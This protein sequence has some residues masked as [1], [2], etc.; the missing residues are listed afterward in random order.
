M[1]A[2]KDIS[3]GRAYVELLIKNSQFYKQLKASQKQLEAWGKSIA[4]IGA[5][6]AAAGAAI[7]APLTAAAH[8]FAESGKELFN[9]SARTGVSAQALSEL[10]FAARRTG[11]DAEGLEHS[12]KHMTKHVGEATLGNQ[13]AAASL[14]TIGLN[15][16]MLR[17]LSIDKQ[18]E[19]IAD[20]IA[21]V[22]DPSVKAAAA[23]HI[24]G[25]NGLALMPL[26]IQGSRGIQALRSEAQKLGVSRSDTSVA[27]A[28]QLAGL[29]GRMKE[30][31]NGTV[32]AI[33]QALAPTMIRI[34]QI[35]NSAL[36]LVQ[37]FVKQYGSLVPVIFT[38][39]SGLVI[40]G[41]AIAAFGGSVFA[42]GAAFG[43]I[44][45]TVVA[46]GGFLATPLGI[47]LAIGAAVL[48]AAVQ[49]MRL[50]EI[51]KQ[52]AGV[53]WQMI[54]PAVE[55]I[56]A[57]F[58]GIG[59]AIAGGDLVLAGKIAV[60]GLR[61]V[62]MQGI[63]LLVQSIHATL[64]ETF[65]AIAEDIIQGDLAGAWRIVVSGMAS[66]WANFA[67]GMVS[68]FVSAANVAIGAWKKAVGD[69]A[70]TILQKSSEGGIEGKF[71]SAVIGVDMQ[72]EA[73]LADKLNKQLG[74]NENPVDEAKRAARQGVNQMAAP[75]E[76]FFAG[77]NDAA[78]GKAAEA[79][80]AH[81][82]RLGAPRTDA[83]R[84]MER[85]NLQT[86]LDNLNK[87]A[88]AAK[89]K[90]EAEA[91]N[92]PAPQQLGDFSMGKM[93]V[94]GGFSAEGLAAQLQGG[95]QEAMARDIG[96]IRREAVRQRLLLE[97]L[98]KKNGGLAIA[99]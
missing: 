85:A 14:A 5:S 8:T 95:P 52:T 7:V 50:T 46:V 55:T 58:A 40:A 92:R 54:L 51:G 57:T 88:A 94:A 64:G 4:V 56:K 70:S 22:R 23:L 82:G 89:K 34:V 6:M 79:N 90:I 83:A 32:L 98:N 42:I 24:F 36:L 41:T 77:M 69:L 91:A 17:G 19:V 99:A 80:R 59:N 76:E 3:A 12:L 10:G 84:E 43:A 60:T 9:M 39:G 73:A 30:I 81:A 20:R 63:D 33:G 38:V 1:A 72:K 97:N 28:N 16:N 75:I 61:I 26:M 45:S 2:G 87:Q 37:K 47:T 15:A 74:I 44:A 11:T 18:F 31:I 78:G 67:K 49:W 62:F 86:E 96:D 71:W 29:F 93:T 25:K 21:G 65:G 68:V 13:E 48:Y 35:Q 66:L 27:Q 53:L